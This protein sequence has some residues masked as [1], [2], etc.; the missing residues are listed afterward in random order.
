MKKYLHKKLG[1]F[2]CRF[3]GIVKE[4]DVVVCVWCGNSYKVKGLPYIGDPD[5]KLKKLN[6]N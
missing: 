5:F 6:N 2:Q 3:K 1:W 4:G